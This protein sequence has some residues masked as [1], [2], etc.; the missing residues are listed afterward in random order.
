MAKATWDQAEELDAV[1]S[2]RSA[3]ATASGHEGSAAPQQSG[4]GVLATWMISIAAHILLFA[5]MFMVPWLSET[6][7]NNAELPI[8]EAQLIGEVRPASFSPG[9]SPDLSDQT[10]L[11]DP[12]ES[13]LEPK[14]FD[15]LADL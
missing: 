13:N 15:Q 1:A 14:R 6:M 11:H 4:R 5:V 2:A 8:P 12:S 3:L 10:K 7:L 9:N